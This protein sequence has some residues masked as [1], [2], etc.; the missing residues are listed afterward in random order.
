MDVFNTAFL[1]AVHFGNATERGVGVQQR[2]QAEAGQKVSDGIMWRK[3]F[4]VRRG[5]RM[6]QKQ[7]FTWEQVSINVSVTVTAIVGHKRIIASLVIISA[8][9]KREVIFL[10]NQ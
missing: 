4:I 6:K 1:A 7:K 2:E 9:R 5:I 3:Y 10:R 8:A